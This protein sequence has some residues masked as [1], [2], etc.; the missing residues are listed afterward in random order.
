MIGHGHTKIE[1]AATFD[2]SVHVVK[3]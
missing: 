3:V 1:G 2:Y